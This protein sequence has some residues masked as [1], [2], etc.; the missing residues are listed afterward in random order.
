[1]SSNTDSSES[2]SNSSSDDQWLCPDN[3]CRYSSRTQILLTHDASVVCD[4]DYADLDYTDVDC[5]DPNCSDLNYT[6]FFV[7][8]TRRHSESERHPPNRKSTNSWVV[9]VRGNETE[10]PDGYPA[11]KKPSL[12]DETVKVLG[13]TS[14]WLHPNMFMESSVGH[15]KVRIPLLR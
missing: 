1:M 5:S 3:G 15:S 8:P 11:N 10:Y 7:T 6:D 4:P 12:P 9:H 13:K 2:S 14:F